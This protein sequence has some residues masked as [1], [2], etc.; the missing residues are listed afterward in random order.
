MT[1]EHANVRP[2]A[3]T[4][5]LVSRNGQSAPSRSKS[6]LSSSTPTARPHDSHSGAR[7]ASLI[8][9][10]VRIGQ[11]DIN[12]LHRFAAI[13]KL[14]ASGREVGGGVDGQG[15]DASGADA[16]SGVDARLASP[17]PPRR[18]HRE[19]YWRDRPSSERE[20]AFGPCAE[21]DR[22]APRPHQD[23]S[24]WACHRPPGKP[25]RRGGP[26]PSSGSA[27]TR[28]RRRDREK[29]SAQRCRGG[30]SSRRATIRSRPSPP[31]AAHCRE[32]PK[33]QARRSSSRPAV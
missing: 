17:G 24:Q 16:P 27:A 7:T 11:F 13:R 4:K 1:P 28:F 12:G 29:R 9:G 32:N 25:P 3:S 5:R 30:C 31:P 2:P 26:S 6:R 8:H 18:L 19:R 14:G 10:G 33:R 15:G 22:P 20:A 23:R 21:F